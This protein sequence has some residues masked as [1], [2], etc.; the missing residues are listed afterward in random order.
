M[1]LPSARLGRLVRRLP[2]GALE[3]SRFA[4]S[5]AEGIIWPRVMWRGAAIVLASVAMKAIAATQFVGAGLAFGIGLAPAEYL[6]LMVVLGVVGYFARIAGGF[7]VG[8]V[9]VLTRLGV[10]QEEALAMALI[11]QASNLLCV[12]GIGAFALWLEGVAL[13]DLRPGGK[14]APG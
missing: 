14:R 9:F 2:R 11:V 3:G 5:F 8:A 4:S 13:A 12:A 7:V 6:F 10:P 1:P